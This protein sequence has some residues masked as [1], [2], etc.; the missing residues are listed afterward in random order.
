MEAPQLTGL[1]LYPTNPP[2]INN[3]V[4]VDDWDFGSTTGGSSGAPYFDQNERVIGQNSRRDDVPFECDP[5][6]GSVFGRF[7][8]SWE[9]GGTPDT[10]LRDWL[11]PAGTN[12]MT[13]NTISTSSPISGASTL[14]FSNSTYSISN[15]PTGATVSWSVSPTNLFVVDSGTGSSFITR[16]TNSFNGQGTITANITGTCGDVTVTKDV[17]VGRPQ[18]NLHTNVTICTDVRSQPNAY[19]L[20]FSSGAETYDLVSNSPNLTVRSPVTPGSAVQ[21]F[22]TV[23]GNYSVTL[24]TS[25]ACGSSQVSMSVTAE[26]CGGR[27]RTAFFAPYPNPASSTIILAPT[28]EVQ[29]LNANTTMQNSTVEQG[30]ELAN[31]SYELYNL[32]GEVVASGK[33]SISELTQ[34]PVFGLEKAHYILK[35]YHRGN[36]E[37]HHILIQ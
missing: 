31:G 20:P 6:K 10:R 34:I 16:A 36:V 26:R 25:N 29:V 33:I 17:W 30:K 4:L 5:D 8:V 2:D 18:A 21:M 22:T 12:A 1:A 11:D 32:Q 7:S 14:C 3:N 28:Q 27:A 35:I 15:L 23:P 13:T 9:G 37:D 19:I 24:T